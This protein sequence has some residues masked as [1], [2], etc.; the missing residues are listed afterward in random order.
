MK[1]TMAK[2]IKVGTAPQQTG[3]KTH[4][5]VEVMRKFLPD[6][7]EE[8][9]IEIAKERLTERQYKNIFGT[10]MEKRKRE[11]DRS[12]PSLCDMTQPSQQYVLA[13]TIEHCPVRVY[14]QLE[15]PS[16][17][18]LEHLARII[19]NIIGWFGTHMYQFQKD[20]MCFVPPEVFEED[21]NR[22]MQQHDAMAYT[23]GD[24]LKKKG[25]SICFVYDFGDEWQHKV[26]L[27][28]IKPLNEPRCILL[29][30][31]GCCPPEDCGGVLGYAEMLESGEY[32]PEE[33]ELEDAQAMVK[34]YVDTVSSPQYRYNS[35]R[36]DLFGF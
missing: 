29:R 36:E 28:S 1:R 18:R 10:E 9:I 24:T 15:V 34:V 7:S 26:R 21:G 17:I 8:Q 25:D 23:L 11:Y 22:W 14:R 12:R 5:V 2:I 13:I 16:N 35:L 4:P 19:I 27:S 31:A 30:G 33:F 20:R 32:K 6:F 3:A